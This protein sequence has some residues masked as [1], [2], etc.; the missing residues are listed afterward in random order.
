MGKLILALSFLSLLT[1]GCEKE[2][3]KDYKIVKDSNSIKTDSIITQIDTDKKIDSSIIPVLQPTKQETE[4]VQKTNKE[5]K[6]IETSISKIPK[7]NTKKEYPNS[8]KS[9]SKELEVNRKVYN[10]IGDALKNLGNLLA[11]NKNN[12]VIKECNRIIKKPSIVP[13]LN[14]NIDAIHY[15]RLSAWFK[16]KD[17][18]R[19]EKECSL[20]NN[21]FPNS[22][23]T[24]G[25]NGLMQGVEGLRK[26]GL[27][28]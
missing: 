6:K 12:D 18:L 5:A 2:S 11:T 21:T 3:K 13:D 27:V 23:Y 15:F 26:A 16:M 1:L 25:V 24:S 8:S 14:D 7:P 4:I 17:Y 19:V 28:K 22:K 10:N 20:F 9:N